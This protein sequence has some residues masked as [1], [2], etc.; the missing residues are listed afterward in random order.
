MIKRIL[1]STSTE[2]I[3]LPWSLVGLYVVYLVGVAVVLITGL[4]EMDCIAIPSEMLVPAVLSIVLASLFCFIVLYLVGYQEKKSKVLEIRANAMKNGQPVDEIALAKVQSFNN[5]YVCALLVGAG[6]S[7][8]VAYLAMISVVPAN[9]TVSTEID[10]ILASAA[11]AI[12]AS[13]VL[14]R[15]FIH[16]I[17][18][19]TFKSKVI[20]PLT[21]SIIAEFQTDDKKAPALTD[22]QVN[23][24]IGALQNI[25]R[26]D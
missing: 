2:G 20:D 3:V 13:L 22:D 5:I 15:Y 26:K 23:A 6:L 9:L 16:P 8:V 19:G 10:Y 11:S 24:L 7:A 18:D 25:V 21:D 1:P 14:D 4:I 12:V 17:A